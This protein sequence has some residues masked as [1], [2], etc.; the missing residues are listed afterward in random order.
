M[1]AGSDAGQQR[2]PD[3]IGEDGESALTVTT[4]ACTLTIAPGRRGGSP[5]SEVR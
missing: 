1:Q 2:Q 4:A 5:S 3:G